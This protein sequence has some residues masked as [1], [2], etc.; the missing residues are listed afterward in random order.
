MESE[1]L[2]FKETDLKGYPVNFILQMRNRLNDKQVKWQ[3]QKSNHI[4]KARISVSGS[5]ESWFLGSWIPSLY[6]LVTLRIDQKGMDLYYNNSGNS[7]S[8]YY[9]EDER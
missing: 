8:I 6:I 1:L 2:E 4:A 7:S 5:M 3:T 9:R